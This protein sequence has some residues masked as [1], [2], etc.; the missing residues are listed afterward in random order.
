LIDITA[1]EGLH[2]KVIII[3]GVEAH[4]EVTR[5][6]P[7]LSFTEKEKVKEGRYMLC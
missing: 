5:A 6:D 2:G 7:C 3:S 1:D 4:H